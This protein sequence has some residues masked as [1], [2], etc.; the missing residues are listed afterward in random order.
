MLIDKI[1]NTDKKLILRYAIL[2][3]LSF[4]MCCHL[5]YTMEQEP[6]VLG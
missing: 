6:C 2:F 3:I 1:K 4:R 5:F